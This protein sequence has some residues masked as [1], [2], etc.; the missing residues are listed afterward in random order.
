[1]YLSIC[2]NQENR[3]ESVLSYQVYPQLRLSGLVTSRH[4]HPPS[5]LTLLSCYP[6][7]VVRSLTMVGQTKCSQSTKKI[8]SDTFTASK[9]KNTQDTCAYLGPWVFIA[10][11]ELRGLCSWP[12]LLI[13]TQ[14]LKGNYLEILGSK[15]IFWIVYYSFCKTV[16][17]A[18][19]R[20]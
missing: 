11:L 15:R 20:F 9:A 19:L 18:L 16:C 17:T 1:M 13:S 4:F 3:Q 10:F 7:A 14:A 6:S 8:S 2:G 5:P 12:S